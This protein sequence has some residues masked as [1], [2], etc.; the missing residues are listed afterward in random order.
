[1]WLID[2][3]SINTN[4][5]DLALLRPASPAQKGGSMPGRSFDNIPAISLKISEKAPL[6]GEQVALYGVPGAN[7]FEPVIGTGTY[8]GRLREPMR[9]NQ[10][11]DSISYKLLDVVIINPDA[12]NKDSCNFG[13]SGSMAMRADGSMLGPLSGRINGGYGPNKEFQNGAAFLGE[14]P[15]MFN[16]WTNHIEN[17]LRVKLPKE[18]DM[19]LCFYTVLDKTTLGNL[20]A[21]FN[22][23]APDLKPE[24][25]PVSEGKG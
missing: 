20:V 19:T 11:P 8:I 18:K 1:M 25:N 10:S 15:E 12:P 24:D 22:T 6:P 16:S 5:K 7:N 13:A 9:K 3:L 14:T 21:G 4:Y 2:G 23:F 17:S